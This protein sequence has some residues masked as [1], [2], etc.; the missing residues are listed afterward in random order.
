MNE[1]QA[2]QTLLQAIGDNPAREGLLKTPE[3]VLSSLKELC[4]GYHENPAQLF[5]QCCDDMPDYKGEIELR[6]IPFTSL[7]EH[8]LLPFIG[9]AHISYMPNGK[10]YGI[11]RIARLVDIFSRRL[12]LQERLT[13]E[14][15]NA[16]MTYMK[17]KSVRVVL[18]AEHQCLSLRGIQKKGTILKTSTSL[19]G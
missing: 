14:I 15:A 12:Q 10:V 6:D 9:V 17:P 13:S 19:P 3:R 1:I 18:E 7:C 11:S 8:H 2:I 4:A 5:D 16:L